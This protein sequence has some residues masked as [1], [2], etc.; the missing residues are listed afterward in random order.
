M[1]K[2]LLFLIP[3]VIIAALL[4]MLRA[5]GMVAHIVVSVIGLILL[6]S[7]TVATKKHGKFLRL[8][9]LCVYSMPLH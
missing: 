7:Y 8:K 1:K 3:M 4:F 6:V 5:T 9:Y 2:N